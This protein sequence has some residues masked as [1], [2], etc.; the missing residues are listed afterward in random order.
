MLYLVAQRLVIVAIAAAIATILR[1]SLPGILRRLGLER[2]NYAGQ[3]IGTG[4]GLLFVACVLPWIA[5][6]EASQLL[7]LAVIGFGLLGFIDD[8]WGTSEFKGLRGHFR[9]LRSGR[10]TTGLLKAAGGLALSA[11]LAWRI[12]P[13]PAAIVSALLIALSANLFNL[14]D[15]RPLRTLKLFWLCALGLLWTSPL[16]LAQLAGLSLGYAPLEARRRVM[17]GDTGAN[18]L[19]GA[20][21]VAAALALPS[22]AQL[23]AVVL[24]AAFH[25]WAEKHS[26]TA[27]IQSHPMARALDEWGWHRADGS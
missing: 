4:A 18:A 2:T 23:I 20:V 27:W 9:A 5:L 6:R 15:L 24:V 22:E 1:P 21:G 13:G 26:L 10:V 7:C 11:G 14:L 8:R 17:L 16:L 19:G 25:Y 12:A 3:P